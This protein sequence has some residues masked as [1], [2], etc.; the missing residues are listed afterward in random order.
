M[1][2]ARLMFLFMIIGAL[3][4]FPPASHAQTETLIQGTTEKTMD[5]D[6]ATSWSSFDWEVFMNVFPALNSHVPGTGDVGPGLAESYTISEDG[7]EY[8]FHLRKGLKFADGTPFDAHAVKWSIDRVF[9]LKGMPAFLVTSYVD[10]VE[11]VGPHDAKFVL[12]SPVSFFPALATRPPYAPLNPKQYPQDQA[13]HFPSQ[14]QW[15]KLGGLGPYQIVSFKRDQEVVL[16]ANPN[17]YGPKPKT[18]RIVLRHF[19]DSTT[20][21]LSLERGEIDLAF[22]TLNPSDINDLR[23]SED[24]KTVEM[25]SPYSRYLFFCTAIPPF[26]DKVLRQAVAATIDRPAIIQKVFLGQR[27]PLYS[28]VPRGIWSHMDVF[29][30]SSGDCN[31]A[32]AKEL[33]ASRGYNENDKLAFDLWYTPSKWGDTEVDFAAVLK[34]QLEATETMRVDV[35]SAEWATFV[36]Y[37]GKK[38]MPVYMVQFVP[39]YIDP[40]TYLSSFG[41]TGASASY[42]IFY[43]NKDWDAMLSK[44]MVETDKSERIKIY[45]KLQQQWRTECPAIPIL[46]GTLH[47]FTRKNIE[48]VAFDPTGLLLYQNLEQVK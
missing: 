5:L 10:H 35:K 4:L 47:L 45:E 7:K 19:A 27:K 30:E 36:E 26:N 3:A 2:N 44:G 42:G 22:K 11:V 23:K 39:D 13:L 14:S 37:M 43:S 20:L 48:G 9:K 12:K 32:K 33:L 15:G 31:V 21:R 38:V 28:V 24:L 18:R 41:S 17:Y 46:Q 1:R 25:I 6:P 8:T 29:K 16:E 34:E 40:D